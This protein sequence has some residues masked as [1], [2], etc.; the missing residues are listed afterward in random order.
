LRVFRSVGRRHLRLWGNV[1][2]RM[3]APQGNNDMKTKA[4]TLIELL[5]VMVIA[6]VIM[7]VA[8]PGFMSMSKGK[9]MRMATRNIHSTLSLSRQWAI[10][11]RENVTVRYGEFFNGLHTEEAGNILVDSGASFAGNLRDH[12]L[13]NITT[14][15]HGTITTNTATTISASGLTW[16]KYDRYRIDERPVTLSSYCI[17]GENEMY[18]QKSEPL[19]ADTVFDNG[20]GVNEF[21]DLITFTSVGGLNSET[22]KIIIIAD[23]HNKMETVTICVQWATGGIAVQ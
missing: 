8:L 10:T 16:T 4:F 14:G 18:I 20:S 19:A 2:G 13:Y 22:N 21:S 1:F 12:V 9:A 5:V 15:V 3:V 6:A 7:A 17:N 11:H 23:R